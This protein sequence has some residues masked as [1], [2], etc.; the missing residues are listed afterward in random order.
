MSDR[1]EST[2]GHWSDQGDLDPDT[3]VELEFETFNDGQLGLTIQVHGT[4]ISRTEPIGRIRPLQVVYPPRTGHSAS[5]F[6]FKAV[7]DGGEGPMPIREEIRVP[8][9]RGLIT[10]YS[11]R[12]DFFRISFS[13]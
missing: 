10:R 5:G 12:T 6:S 4:I 2:P 1:P 7:I 11:V 8:D 3:H 9:E 13:T